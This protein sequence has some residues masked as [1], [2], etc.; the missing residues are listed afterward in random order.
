MDDA[1]NGSKSVE[2]SSRVLL[3]LASIIQVAHAKAITRDI[4]QAVTANQKNRYEVSK[5]ALSARE[6][7]N[8]LQDILYAVAGTV[9]DTTHITDLTKKEVESSGKMIILNEKVT[10]MMESTLSRSKQVLASA[11]TISEEMEHIASASE[12]LTAMAEELKATLGK[13]KV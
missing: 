1:A 4:E 5:G 13:I 6:A 2:E 11:E 3:E 10:V 12:Q 8:A 7:G 9:E